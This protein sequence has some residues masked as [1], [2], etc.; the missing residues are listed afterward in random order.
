MYM[1]CRRASSAAHA[2]IVTCWSMKSFWWIVWTDR[3]AD[4]MMVIMEKR[5]I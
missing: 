1:S 3:I 2:H 4:T 5:M